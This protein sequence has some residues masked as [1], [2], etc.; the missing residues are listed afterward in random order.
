[1]APVVHCV[2][3]LLLL[4]AWAGSAGGAVAAPRQALRVTNSQSARPYDPSKP[5]RV[6][7]WNIQVSQ[8]RL[9]LSANARDEPPPPR[10]CLPNLTVPSP[11]PPSPHPSFSSRQYCAG[12]SAHFFY[13]GGR[14]VSAPSPRRQTVRQTLQRVAEVIAAADADVVLL[15]EVDRRSLRTGLIDEHAA[16]LAALNGAGRAGPSGR[17]EPAAPGGQYT[18]HASAWYWRVPWV[19]HPAHQHVGRVNMHLSVFS[20]FELS[21]ASRIALPLLKE[22]LHRRL[23]NLRRAVLAVSLAGSDGRPLQLWNT[24]LSA[25]SNGDGTLGAQVR[26]LS[27]LAVGA[28]HGRW[29][30]AGDLNALPPGVPAARHLEP[31]EAALY[32]ESDGASESPIAPLYR[33]ATPVLPLSE[34]SDPATAHRWFSYKPFHSGEA[35]RTIDHAFVGSELAVERAEVLRVDG[36]PSDHLPLVMDVRSR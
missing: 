4:L 27:E 19:P 22:P 21:G 13:D 12:T 15:Q 35:D 30:L 36:W 2:P 5:L 7:S 26:R 14:A 24:H 33:D 6:L 11:H 3:F 31:A 18:S 25:F 29:L 1:M 28:G 32:G 23:F 16:L 17:A 34:M 10:A 8:A 9:I 20:R